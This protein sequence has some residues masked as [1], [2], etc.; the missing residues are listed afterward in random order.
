MTVCPECR[1]RV[2]VRARWQWEIDAGIDTGP[3]RVHHVLPGTFAYNPDGVTIR[4][5]G[6]KCPGSDQPAEVAS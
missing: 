4:T 3:A 6:I 1:C 5:Q 2:D